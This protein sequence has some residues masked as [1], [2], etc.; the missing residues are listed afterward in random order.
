MKTIFEVLFDGAGEGPAGDGT[1]IARFRKRAEAEAFASR[2]TCYGRPCTAE[3][4]EVSRRLAARY[5]LA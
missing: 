2:N 3:A 5:G 1:H 4:R